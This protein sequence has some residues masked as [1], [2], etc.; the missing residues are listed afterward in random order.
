[1]SCGDISWQPM[2]LSLR[3]TYNG[4]K[5]IDTLLICHYKPFMDEETEA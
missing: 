4:L 3:C 2:G 1:M 5:S